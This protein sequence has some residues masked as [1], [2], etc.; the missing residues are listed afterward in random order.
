MA[1]SQNYLPEK[2]D[3]SQCCV[4]ATNAIKGAKTKQLNKIEENLYV[5]DFSWQILETAVG[6]QFW[7]DILCSPGHEPGQ[8]EIF[9]VLF[10]MI[11][12]DQEQA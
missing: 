6:S 12:E 5:S 3:A 4:K 8:I 11:E 10:R 2:V 7:F 1:A 9:P